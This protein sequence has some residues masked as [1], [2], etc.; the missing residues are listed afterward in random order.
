MNPDKALKN[1]QKWLDQ[2]PMPQE[3][4]KDEVFAVLLGLGFELWGKTSD[5][6]TFRW[7]HPCLDG[8]FNY[9]PSGTL[10]LSVGHGKGKKTVTR[11]G[12]VRKLIRALN[13]YINYGK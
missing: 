5:H 2:N 8:E 1:A 4:G 7:H 3:L 6:T 13:L 9:F 11:I 12:S 10:P